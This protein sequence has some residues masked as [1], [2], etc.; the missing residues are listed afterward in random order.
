[1]FRR[2][3]ADIQERVTGTMAISLMDLDGIAIDSLNPASV[4]LDVLRAEF[5]GFVKSIRL[6]S[7]DLDTGEVQQFTLVTEKYTT[8]LSAVTGDYYI[9]LVLEPGGNYGRARFELAKARHLLRDEL[10]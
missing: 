4:E 10:S 9:L 7:T 5:G 8:M 3:L 1:M 2:V 6:S